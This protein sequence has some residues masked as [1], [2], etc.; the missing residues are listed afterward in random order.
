MNYCL[1][2]WIANLGVVPLFSLAFFLALPVFLALFFLLILVCFVRE[3]ISQSLCLRN[4]SFYQKGFLSCLILFVKTIPT[5]FAINAP[6]LD[7]FLSKGEQIELKIDS[8]QSFSVGN[9]EVIS[10]RYNDKKKTLHVKAKSLGF[11]DLVIW[12]KSGNK[13]IYNFYITSKRK[14]LSRME[15]LG[16]IRHTQITAKVKGPYILLK[17]E[18]SSLSDY[19][20]AKELYLNHKKHIQFQIS[21]TEELRNKIYADIYQ[22]FYLQNTDAIYC[23]QR[24]LIFSCFYQ[25]EEEIKDLSDAFPN[26][27][28]KFYHQ[29]KKQKYQN[30]ELKFTILGLHANSAQDLSSGLNQIK[31]NLQNLVENNMATLESGEIFA[32]TQNVSGSLNALPKIRTTFE[33][34][35]ELRQGQERSFVESDGEKS[36]TKWKFSGLKIKGELKWK[37]GRSF[38]SYDSEFSSEQDGII[39]GPMGRATIRIRPGKRYQLFSLKLDQDQSKTG[40]VPGLKN[41]PLLKYLFQD[42]SKIKS[43]NLILCYVEMKEEK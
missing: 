38:L 36:I 28:V 4:Y 1:S 3:P 35:F 24:E 21:L 14:Q 27:L 22:Y 16:Q 18:I 15:L 10:Y 25:G 32:Q 29:N 26:Y 37:E 42:S 12:T 40:G 41:L 13:T 11:S 31:T 43:H 7:H 20:V 33:T 17:G 9:R 19:F 30:Y 34:P 5:T 8:M 6:Q 2:G 23:R 39:S